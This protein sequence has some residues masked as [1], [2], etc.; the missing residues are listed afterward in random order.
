MRSTVV[1]MKDGQKFQGPIWEFRPMEG[2]ISLAGVRDD[3][4]LLRLEIKDI[5]SAVTPNE[6]V[7]I[8]KIEDVD[9]LARAAK[10]VEDAKKYGWK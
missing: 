9:E 8:G 7:G 2:Y 6:R 5:A 4:E 3:G 1:V 10:H